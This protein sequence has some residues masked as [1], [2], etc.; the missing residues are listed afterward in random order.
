MKEG[1]DIYGSLSK[2]YMLYVQHIAHIPQTLQMSELH[3]SF[4]NLETEVQRT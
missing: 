1:A 3:L 2:Y 4:Y